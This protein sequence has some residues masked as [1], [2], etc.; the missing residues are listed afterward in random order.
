MNI[1]LFHVDCVDVEF[2]SA[3]TK[4]KG[5]ETPL[6]MIH[7]QMKKMKVLSNLRIKS[8]VLESLIFWPVW[9]AHQGK[10]AH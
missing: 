3:L 10:L 6:Q 2:R 9:W 1:S 5:N 4:L 7:L 8:E